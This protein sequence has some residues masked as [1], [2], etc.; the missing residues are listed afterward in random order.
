MIMKDRERDTPQAQYLTPKVTTG[1]CR[2]HNCTNILLALTSKTKWVKIC[3]DGLFV[4]PLIP[5]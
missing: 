5:S 1:S 2:R 4:P 3:A